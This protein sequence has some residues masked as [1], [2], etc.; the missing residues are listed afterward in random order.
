MAVDNLVESFAKAGVKPLRVGFAG[1]V[2]PALHRYTLDSFIE[3]HTSKPALDK[4]RTDLASAERRLETVQA[5]LLGIGNNESKKQ[6]LQSKRGKISW[7][8]MMIPRL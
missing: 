3:T 5:S 6:V 8:P 7:P 2:P 1:R 4:L